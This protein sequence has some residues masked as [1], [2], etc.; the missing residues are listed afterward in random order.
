MAAAWSFTLHV[1]SNFV[2]KTST[3]FPS[4]FLHLPLF[5]ALDFYF[6][7]FGTQ[8]HHYHDIILKFSILETP[9]FNP[10]SWDSFNPILC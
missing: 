6:I 10:I 1:V 9:Q 4:L 7:S 8:P 5:V 3:R 2:D